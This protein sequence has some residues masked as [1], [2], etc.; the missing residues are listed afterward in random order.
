MNRLYAR[1]RLDVR[2][3]HLAFA[4]GALV[5]RDHDAACAGM[6][7]MWPAPGAALACYSVR[8]GFHLLLSALDLM[9]GDEVLFSAV[10]HPDMPRIAA[11]HGLVAVPVDLDP[12]TLA[13][14]ATALARAISPRSRVLVVA[15]LFGGHVELAPLAEVCGAHGVVLVEDCAQS[16]SGPPD[17]GDRAAL[18]SMFSFGMLKTA[19]A[20]GGAMLTVRDPGLL[21]RMRA[22]Q[23]RWPVQRRGAHLER[24]ARTAAF[25]F[26]TRPCVYAVV[27]RVLGVR[28]DGLVN[29]AARAFPS[30]S[31]AELVDRLERRPGA[32]LLR[33]MRHRLES[34]DH[35]RLFARA[36]AGELLALM[37]PPGMHVGG[38]AQ[39]H[40]H[41]LFPVVTDDAPALIEAAH[42]AGFDAA[43]SA[44]SVKAI[45]APADRPETAPV[46]ARQ[47]MSRLV[48]VPAYPELPPGSLARLARALER[49]P[50]TADAYVAV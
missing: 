5:A 15:H 11:H 12:S 26:L 37:A 39:G 35:A 47:I 14:T 6:E 34:F 7:S 4:V 3:R 28:F 33:L 16:Y 19:T 23:S 38:D 18:V 42:V 22:I 32:P 27:A 21:A 31:T 25:V 20:L 43:R 2:P 49:Q 10:T 48:F 50:A 46:R 1:H 29:S 9:P 17:A 24:I 41:W 36:A 45:P 30:G 44:S 8:S 13:P 40:T